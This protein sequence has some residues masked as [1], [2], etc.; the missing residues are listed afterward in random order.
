MNP[1]E[2]DTDIYQLLTK[3]EIRRIDRL[4]GNIPQVNELDYKLI[5]SF[6]SVIW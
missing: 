6:G 1:Y 2:Q 4:E 3:S 5:Q